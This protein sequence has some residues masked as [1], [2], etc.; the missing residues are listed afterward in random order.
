[1]KQWKVLVTAPR[2]VSVIERYEQALGEAGCNVVARR[3]E[4][5]KCGAVLKA[6][7]PFG[8]APR[9]VAT[10]DGEDRRCGSRRATELHGVDALG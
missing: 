6:L 3:V 2:A 10:L 8:P 9:G 5:Q 1:M 7:R 4:L